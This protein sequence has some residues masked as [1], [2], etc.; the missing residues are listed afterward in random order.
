MHASS[1]FK[2]A[3]LLL[4]YACNHVQLTVYIYFLGYQME[5]L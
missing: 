3:M 4:N 5:Q 1:I 2:V